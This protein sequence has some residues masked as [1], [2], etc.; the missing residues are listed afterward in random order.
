ML[1]LLFLFTGKK[2]NKAFSGTDAPKKNPSA[3]EPVED[4]ETDTTDSLEN[5]EDPDR[6]RYGFFD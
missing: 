5:A 4:S 1:I 2:K 6:D 3:Q